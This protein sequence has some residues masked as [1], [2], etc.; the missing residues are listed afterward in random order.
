[1]TQPDVAVAVTMTQPKPLV[2]QPA[3]AVTEA[4][5]WTRELRTLRNGVFT[6]EVA[7]TVNCVL[8]LL[9]ENCSVEQTT[10]VGLA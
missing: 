5:L 4:F 8:E 9:G 6:H 3:G 1:M 2:E 10:S 7:V